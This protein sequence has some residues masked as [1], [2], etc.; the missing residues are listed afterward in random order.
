[1]ENSTNIFGGERLDSK[2]GLSKNNLTEHLARYGQVPGNTEAIILDIGCGSG[3][4]S[5][6]LAKKFKK[7]Y[8]VDVAEDAIAYAK[9]NWAT[10]N[11]EFMVGSGTAIPFADKT[12]DAVAA[13]EVFEH[14]EKW[15][16]FL[17]EI[18]RVLKPGGKL[19]MSTPNKDIYSPG[20]K[21]PINP[22]HFFEMTIPEF[23]NALSNYFVIE[24][25]CGQR[26]PIYN[27]HFVWKIANPLFKLFKPIIGYKAINT[28]KLKIINWIKPDLELSDIV[29]STDEAFLK[30]SRFMLAH[31]VNSL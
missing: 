20:T 12:F 16:L 28:C 17:Q 21:K 9:K 30:K 24:K 3:H 1:M 26:T 4:G 11:A 5:S 27:D 14:I 19:Y 25:F 29:F 31:C 15:G 2:S 6:L 13:F 7:V 18:K 8:G 10:L 23:K 22:H